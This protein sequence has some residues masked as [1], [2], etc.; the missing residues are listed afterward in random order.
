MPSEHAGLLIDEAVEGDRVFEFVKWSF[1]D[2][3][4]DD[5]QENVN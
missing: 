5:I 2:P 1:V 3:G 4:I